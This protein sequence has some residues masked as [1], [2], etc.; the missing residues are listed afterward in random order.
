MD[1]ELFRSVTGAKIRLR[2]RSPFITVL[3]GHLTLL[4][5][6]DDHPMP[7]ACVDGK[8]MWINKKFWMSLTPGQREFLLAHEALHAALGHCWRGSMLEAVRWNKACDY[9]INLILRKADFELIDDILI[10]DKYAKMTALEVYALLESITMPTGGPGDGGWGGFG[11]DVIR[12][13]GS[14]SDSEKSAAETRWRGARAAAR[15]AEKMYGQGNAPMGA[16]IE[17]VIED[18]ALNWEEHLWRAMSFDN[19]DFKN[20][21]RRL[22]HDETYV[23]DLESDESIVRVAVCIDTSG[24]CLGVLGKFIGAVRALASL[25][26]RED[27]PVYWEDAALVG[28]I[29]L[30]Q[31]DQPMGGGGTSFVPFFEEVEKMGYEHVVYLTDLYGT[32]PPPPTKAKTLWIVPAGITVVPPFGTVA[33]ILVDY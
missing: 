16:E 31:L 3:V 12:V 23:E 5:L 17:V 9:V 20:F 25:Y 2:S 24:S 21:D 29:P 26:G 10:D 8:R 28:P 30:N 32:F 11:A 4:E 15:T 19:A 6:S 14:M 1:N 27:L 7:T 33:K 13:G 22:I 18:P